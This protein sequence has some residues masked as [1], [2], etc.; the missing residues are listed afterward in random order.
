[1]LGR[2][3]AR[4]LVPHFYPL[5]FDLSWRLWSHSFVQ[6]IPEGKDPCQLE[7]VMVLPLAWQRPVQPPWMPWL[8]AFFKLTVLSPETPAALQFYEAFHQ[9]YLVMAPTLLDAFSNESASYLYILTDGHRPKNWFCWC[10]SHPGWSSSVSHLLF[11]VSCTQLRMSFWSDYRVWLATLSSSMIT[12][13]GYQPLNGLG[14]LSLGRWGD[15]WPL[16]HRDGR[17]SHDGP[18]GRDVIFLCFLTALPK[19]HFIQHPTDFQVYT[20]L[21]LSSPASDV[22]CMHVYVRTNA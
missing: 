3:A 4:D 6:Y 5:T 7:R 2:V 20:I 10:L 8:K 11:L 9:G 17:P 15:K 1:M 14:S 18:R 22:A 19:L 12:V 16:A 13:Y 21:M